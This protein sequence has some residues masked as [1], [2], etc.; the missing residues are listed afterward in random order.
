M[1]EG[2]FFLTYAWSNSPCTSEII[3]DFFL[4]FSL[5]FQGICLIVNTFYP[6]LSIMPVREK[7]NDP[8]EFSIKLLILTSSN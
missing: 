7:N 8:K 5:Q 6:L 4:G 3:S 2:V 1:D